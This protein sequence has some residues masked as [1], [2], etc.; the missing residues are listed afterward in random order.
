MLA[1]WVAD[2]ARGLCFLVGGWGHPDAGT[3]LAHVA[4]HTEELHTRIPQ[5]LGQMQTGKAGNMFVFIT[6]GR[7]LGPAELKVMSAH[8]CGLRFGGGGEVH[9]PG[10]TAEQE[11]ISCQET[12]PNK[13]AFPGHHSM[14]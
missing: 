3:D 12:Q 11:R 9:L 1:I 4:C 8:T 13:N 7:P 5:P 10:D 14:P 2:K 6:G